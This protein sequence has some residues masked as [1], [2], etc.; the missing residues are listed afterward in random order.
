MGMTM[1]EITE[2][3]ICY[4]GPLPPCPEIDNMTDEEVE[5]EFQKRFGKYLEEQ[6]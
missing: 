4:D 3:Y 2:K 5:L 1:E 6:K